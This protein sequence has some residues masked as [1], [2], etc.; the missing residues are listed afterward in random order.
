MCDRHYKIM[1]I[2]PNSVEVQDVLTNN[3][4]PSAQARDDGKVAHP[5]V[6]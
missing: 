2:S 5:E 3:R 4:D 6:R 1:H